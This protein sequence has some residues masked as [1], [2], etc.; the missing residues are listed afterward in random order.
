M[1]IL[2]RKIFGRIAHIVRLTKSKES[3]ETKP[4]A[5]LVGI[6]STPTTGQV[7]RSW[8]GWPQLFGTDQSSF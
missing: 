2:L 1:Y 8:A 6:D 4:S 7:E 5:R 3:P